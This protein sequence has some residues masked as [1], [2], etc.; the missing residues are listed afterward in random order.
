MAVKSLILKKV[1]ME[2]NSKNINSPPTDAPM[3]ETSKKRRKNKKQPESYRT[4]IFKVLK[5]VHGDIGISNKAMEIMN[6]FVNDML[7][8]IAQEASKL[9]KYNKKNTMSS[10]DIETAVK[11]VLHG[12]LAKHA[13]HEGNK[14]VKHFDKS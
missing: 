4:Y 12:E 7:E 2:N 13:V 11:L 14:A 9:A 1:S 5:E 3:V 10:R 8:K 6:S